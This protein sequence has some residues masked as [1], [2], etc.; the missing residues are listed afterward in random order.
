MDGWVAVCRLDA[1]PALGAR[2]LERPG[3]IPIALFRTSDDRVF[4]LDDRCPHRAGPLSQGLVAGSRV[5]CP[6]HGWTIELDSGVAVAP[7]EGRTSTYPVEIRDGVVWMRRIDA[8]GAAPAG[9]CAVDCPAIAT[10]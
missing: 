1:L 8:S 10:R 2:A 5:T 7:D 9:A 4:A 3:A 6:L